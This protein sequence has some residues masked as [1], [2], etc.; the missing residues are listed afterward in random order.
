MS[1]STSETLSTSGSERTWG[2]LTIST[3]CQSRLSTVAQK[4]C[5]PLR[6][7]RTVLQEWESISSEKYSAS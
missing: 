7:T 3:H 6:S 2:G 4:N 5:S 1:C